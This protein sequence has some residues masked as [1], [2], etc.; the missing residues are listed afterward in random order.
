MQHFDVDLQLAERV[1]AN[2]LITGEPGV[3]KAH[4][5]RRVHNRSRRCRAPLVTIHCGG[6]SDALLARALSGDAHGSDQTGDDRRAGRLD[7]ANHGSLLMLN[8]DAIGPQTQGMLLRVLTASALRDPS[9][10]VDVRVIATATQSLFERVVSREFLDHLYYRL[11]AIHVVVSPLRERREDIPELAAQ[12]LRDLCV[13]RGTIAPSITPA[14]MTCL[15]A[16]E[17][18]RNIHE[19]REVLERVLV[20]GHGASIE[21]EDLPAII[22]GQPKD[23]RRTVMPR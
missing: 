1:D 23:G 17:W 11:N 6:V 19:L 12:V 9:R 21:P 22:A 2:V 16:Y 15:Q 13:R 4:R 5:A 20:A 10:G 7:R 14:A 8:V 3:G 18:P